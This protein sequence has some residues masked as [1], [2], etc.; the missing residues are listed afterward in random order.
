MDFLVSW[1][2]TLENKFTVFLTIEILMEG[3]ILTMST[4]AIVTS[5]PFTAISSRF[6]FSTYT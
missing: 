4:Y 3:Y 5:Y 2:G 6:C 1:V